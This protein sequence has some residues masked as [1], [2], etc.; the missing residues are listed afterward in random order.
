MFTLLPLRCAQNGTANNC[1]LDTGPCVR[2][3][4]SLCARQGGTH[5]SAVLM[6]SQHLPAGSGRGQRVRRFG[7]LVPCHGTE[8]YFPSAK[9]VS[10]VISEQFWG[11]AVRASRD[12]QESGALLNFGATRVAC[13]PRI[14]PNT[15][16]WLAEPEKIMPRPT[17]A[18]RWRLNRG[19][20]DQPLRPFAITSLKRR[21]K[22][23]ANER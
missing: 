11:R 1:I 18:K 12:S 6:Q 5:P 4:I 8:V 14:D 23:V 9:P 2:F 21:D 13:I 16:D 20:C 17:P 3:L 19:K 22:L 7:H 15:T 10:S